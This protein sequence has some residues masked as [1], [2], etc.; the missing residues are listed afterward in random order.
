MEKSKKDGVVYAFHFIFQLLLMMTSGMCGLD[1]NSSSR[2][3][4]FGFFVD[5][6]H[7]DVCTLLCC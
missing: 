3:E 1:W 6:D 7:D 5:D 4:A 2:P